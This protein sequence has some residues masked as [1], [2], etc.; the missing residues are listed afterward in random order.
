MRSHVTAAVIVIAVLGVCPSAL[1]QT[2]SITELPGPYAWGGINDRGEVAFT[3]DGGNVGVYVNGVVLDRGS[4]G[5]QMLPLRMNESGWIAGSW[6]CCGGERG[7][8]YDG[9]LRDL[10]NP[11][12]GPSYGRSGARGINDAGAVVGYSS[13]VDPAPPAHHA[14]LYHN[15]VATN[16]HLTTSLQT[17]FESSTAADIN[18]SYQIVGTVGPSSG[19][20]YPFILSGGVATLIGAGQGWASAIS[21]AGDVTGAVQ[22]A[23]GQPRRAFLYSAGMLTDLGTLGGSQ[24]QGLGINDAAQVV[25]YSETASGLR[26][27]LYQHGTMIDLTSRIP[28]GSGWTLTYAYGINSSGWIVGEGILNG[29]TRAFLLRPD[30]TICLLYD[31]TKTHK[32]GSTVPIKI[33]LCSA[34]GSNVSGAHIALHADA[35]V[36]VSNGAEGLPEDAGHANPDSNFRFDAGL[37]SGGGYIFNLKT[38][39][40]TAGSYRLRVQALDTGE[41]FLA[42]FR[43]R[44]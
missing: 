39:G 5:T 11:L 8:F 26:A 6:N 29:S 9:V 15:G 44:N 20:D 2:Y 43:L 7:F 41:V 32:A 1:A 23:A 12:G 34:D 21:N 22:H 31:P 30:R 10:T 36:Q 4:L 3:R 33:Q 25:G 27:F 28:G 35:V 37:G 13:L 19:G 18:N 40:L 14:F 38:T 24:S 17:L 42:E 16:L